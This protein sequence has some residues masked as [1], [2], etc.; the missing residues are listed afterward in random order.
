M[1]KLL[2]ILFLI[3]II[4]ACISCDVPTPMQ[5]L[6]SYKIYYYKDSSTDLCF[7]GSG[8]NRSRAMAHVP[9]TSKVL[10]KIN[11]GNFK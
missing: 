9:C 11:K 5:E 6:Y 8:I 10:A 2:T 3:I 1:D 4:L 7:A